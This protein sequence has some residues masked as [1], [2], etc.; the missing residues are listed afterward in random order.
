MLALGL[1]SSRVRS[2]M[3]ARL[4]PGI[5]ALRTRRLLPPMPHL[6]LLAAALLLSFVPHGLHARMLSGAMSS[7]SRFWQLVPAAASGRVRMGTV[8]LG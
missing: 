5:G 3:L 8:L 6:L 2:A 7:V 4:A 1:T